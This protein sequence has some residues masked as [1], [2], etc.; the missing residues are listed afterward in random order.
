LS[1]HIAR[2]ASTLAQSRGFDGLAE[3]AAVRSQIGPPTARWALAII[4]SRFW[5]AICAFLV[6]VWILI[7]MALSGAASA[8]V[9]WL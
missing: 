2:H 6:G 4:V 9:F 7:A 1:I 3:L 8:G 5:F